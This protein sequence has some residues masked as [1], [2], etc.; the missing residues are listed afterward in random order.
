MLTAFFI[1]T[2]IGISE[3]SKVAVA[4]FI[5][6][7]S[8]IFLL[9]VFCLLYFA[10]NGAAVLIENFHVPVNG[11]ITVALFFG[12]SAAMLGISGFESSANFV[13]EQQ[14]GVFPKTLRNMW[15]AVTIINPVIAFL[16]ICIIPM[17][18]VGENKEAFL[19][20]IGN[21]TGGNWL[22]TVISI[23]AVLVLS[24]AVLTSFVGVSGL[25][26]RM[27]LDRILPQFLIKETKRGSS[28]RILFIFYL[29]CISILFIT[30][31]DLEAMAGVYTISF[32]TVMGYFAIGNLLLKIKRSR[33][34]RPVYASPIAVFIAM[35]GISVALYG[36][37]KMH[38]EYLVVFLQ[39]FVPAVI[40]VYALMNRND[41]LQFLLT[42]LKS[43]L[44]EMRKLSRLS[45]WIIRGKLKELHAQ[46]FVFFSKAD[47]ISILNNVMIY[48]RENEITSRVKIVTVLKEGQVI[49]ESFR[50]DFE[51]LDRV[52]NDIEMEYVTLQ[53]KFGPELIAQL[54]KEWNIPTNFMFIS[55]PGDKFPYK[56]SELGGV[57]L[58]L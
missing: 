18:E 41:I 49:P 37:I 16:A 51:V 26:K 53:G 48:I 54:S 14:P 1:L 32:L 29:L 12:F 4:I 35:L 33:L 23:D 34:P 8:S 56:V 39:Y 19:S 36:N 42:I 52:Y 15:L 44:E 55:S 10:N 2:A 38:P 17:A 24:G 31:G 28:P 21:Q 45:Q 20:Y 7:L 40:V 22:A 3:S 27:T 11:S 58:I 47:D 30:L 25:M 50:S 43:A 9:I 46:Q 5:F 57:R 6:H 13:E